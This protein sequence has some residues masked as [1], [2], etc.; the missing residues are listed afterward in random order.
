MERVEQ[1]AVQAVLCPALE[2]MQR[3]GWT[4]DKAIAQVGKLAENTELLASYVDLLVSSRWNAQRV[5]NLEIGTLVWLP[6]IRAVALLTRKREPEIKLDARAWPD[7]S[8]RLEP[9][10]AAWAA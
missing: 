9:P 1:L 10:P 2:T 7:G 3:K 8:S 5:A 6:P 4:K